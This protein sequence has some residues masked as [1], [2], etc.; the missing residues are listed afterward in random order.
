M[1]I[2]VIGPGAIGC[3]FAGFLA[4]AKN[5]IWL[6]DK[7]VERARFI[8]KNGINIEGVSG[9]FAVDVH[10]TTIAKD[11][12]SCDLVIICVK[13]YDTEEAVKSNLSLI[14]DDTLV[15]TVQ[16]GIG[17]VEIISEIIGQDKTVG[18]V[19]SHGATLLGYGHIRHAGR[20]Q[21]MIG[22][23]DGRLSGALK[24]VQEAFIGAKVETK[25]TKD[26]KG[27]IWSKLIV[28]AGINALTA[29]TRLNN[30]MLIEYDGTR[31]ILRLAVS[32]AVKIAKRKRVKL[33]YDDPIQKTESVCRDTSGNVSSMLQDILKRRPTEIDFINGAI[34][35]QGAALG[36]PTPANKVLTDLVKTIE[37]SY[38]RQIE[39]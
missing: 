3:L 33:V 16:N 9:E 10:V 36:I 20:G 11:A 2:A 22:K 26:I 35:R 39:R 21:T 30:G 31:D 17:N 1:K 37:S 32:E 25:V 34:V 28:N 29:L 18:G 12:G 38:G 7:N 6:I 23:F 8:E 24:R 13:S 4:K 5:E 15:L 27:L 14:G 19:T